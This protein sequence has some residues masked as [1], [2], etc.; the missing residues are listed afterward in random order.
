MASSP[1]TFFES[2][3]Q[4]LGILAQATQGSSDG[5][6]DKLLFQAITGTRNER[7]QLE[8]VGESIKSKDGELK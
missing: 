2:V 6:L 7:M 1:E 4:S 3:D 8:D 5:E